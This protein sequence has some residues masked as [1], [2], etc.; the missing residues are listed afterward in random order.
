[1]D[2][3]SFR[4]KYRELC[5]YFFQAGCA[6]YLPLLRGH[7]TG[8]L[9]HVNRFEDYVQDLDCFLRQVAGER[10]PR[11]LFAHSMG[12]GVGARYLQAH[13]D[14]FDRAVLSSPMLCP[15]TGQVPWAVALAGA[16]FLLRRGERAKSP[17][18][19]GK[20]DPNA[21]FQASGSTS[22]ARFRRNLRCRMAQPAYQTEGATNR[23]VYEALALRSR[24]LRR[25]QCKNVTLPVLV[26]SAG[27]DTQVRNREQ[28]AFLRRIPQG[29]GQSFPDGKHELFSAENGLLE[30]YLDCIFNFLDLGNL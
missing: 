5:R 23:W 15:Q 18:F 8:P 17:L 22:E 2:S 7:G 24:V 28:R 21:S 27:Q 13:P 26:L 3:P 11:Y 14:V 30:R 16:R 20:F 4:E 29:M 10:R 6:V 25:R 1:M 9:I 19:S 12:G